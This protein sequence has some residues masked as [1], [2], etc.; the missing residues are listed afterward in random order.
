SLVRGPW[1]EG[2]WGRRTNIERAILLAALVRA[3]VKTLAF[4]RTRR[5]A[6]LVLRY[7]REALEN[8][9]SLLA[10]RVAAYRAG[11]TPEERRRL[12]QDFMRGELLGLV[13]TNALELGVDIGGVD[14]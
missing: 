6:E 3:N 10:R 8:S 12:E 9:G 7:T 14:A 2:R 5:G 11:Y 1:S 4:T 13:S